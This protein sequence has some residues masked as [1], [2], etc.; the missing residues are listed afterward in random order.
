[1]YSAAASRQVLKE[2][3]RVVLSVLLGLV[4]ISSP[5]FGADFSGLVVSALDGDSI[6]VLHN[7]QAERIRLNGI[8]ARRNAKPGG[9]MWWKTSS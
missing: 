7:Q 1:M 9:S 6:E 2:A 8:D 3:M 5:S 4:L